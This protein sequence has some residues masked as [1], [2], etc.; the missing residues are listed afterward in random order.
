MF[1]CVTRSLL[2]SDAAFFRGLGERHVRAVHSQN[3]AAIYRPLEPAQC[4][5][6]VF[7]VAHLD[8]N[9]YVLCQEVVLGSCEALNTQPI[10][11]DAVKGR[12]H[13]QTSTGTGH[14]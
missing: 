13:A 7:L 4:A 2:R 9:A 14:A 1:A 3:A 5:I 10:F 6:Y 11:N 12:F 8:A